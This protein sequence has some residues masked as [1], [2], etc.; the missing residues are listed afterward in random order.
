[1][2][3]ESSDNDEEFDMQDMVCITHKD[4]SI[5]LKAKHVDDHRFIHIESNRRKLQRLFGFGDRNFRCPTISHFVQLMTDKR[6]AAVQTELQSLC[7]GKGVLIPEAKKRRTRYRNPEL[8]VH[9]LLVP[10][11]LEINVY[12]HLVKVLSAKQTAPLYVEDTI[13][14]I[15]ADKVHADNDGAAEPSAQAEAAQRPSPQKA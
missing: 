9:L 12:D 10:E 8:K 15:M 1:M 14:S 6:E 3:F 5:T 4:K 2:A 7:E 11:V 13:I